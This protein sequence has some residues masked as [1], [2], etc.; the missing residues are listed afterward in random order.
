MNR[1]RVIMDLTVLNRGCPEL[2]SFGLL[3]RPWTCSSPGP[4]APLPSGWVVSA[5]SQVGILGFCYF[6]SP[7]TMFSTQDVQRP[8]RLHHHHMYICIHEYIYVYNACLYVYI[9][10]H[11]FS[12]LVTVQRILCVTVVVPMKETITTAVTFSCNSPSRA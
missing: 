7:A 2:M 4:V 8:M 11:M 10:I 6:L 3:C 12:M 9:Y 1:V 5:M